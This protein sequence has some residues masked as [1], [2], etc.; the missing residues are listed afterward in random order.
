ML[1]R[2]WQLEMEIRT[3][4]KNVL[5]TKMTKMKTIYC[6]TNAYQNEYNTN[7]KIKANSSKY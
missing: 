3:D 6:I 2:N 4:K 7:I 5:S 1:K